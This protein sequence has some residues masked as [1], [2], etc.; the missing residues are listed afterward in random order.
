MKNYC[1]LSSSRARRIALAALVAVS[2]SAFGAPLLGQIANNTPYGNQVGGI[3]INAEGVLQNAS[4][5]GQGK[6]SAVL[7]KA[8]QKVPAEMGEAVPLRKVSLRGLEMAIQE[9]N[10]AGKALPD[11]VRF[12]GGLQSIRYV[13]VYPEQRDI[14]LVGPGEGWKVDGRGN[15]IG[16]TTGRP[17]MMLEDLLV[18]L[19]TARQAAQGGIT[20]SIDP[21][22]EGLRQLKS[23]VATLHTIGDPATTS[24]NIGQTLGR[25]QITFHGVPT[26]S[27]FAR[28]L[29]GADYRMKRLA[30]NF[31]SSPVRGLPSFLTMMK[32]GPKGMNSMLPRWWL[33]PKYDSLL[34]DADGLAWELSGG[35][36]KCMTEEDFF[37]ETSGVRE[38]TFKANPVAQKWADNMTDHYDQLAV[39][40]PIFGDL[41]NCMELAIV[42]A[43]IVKADLPGKAGNSLPV[44]MDSTAAPVAEYPVPK[45][46]DSQVSVLKK[47]H[48]WLISA[49]GGVTIQSWM[50]ADKARQSD[51]PAAIRAKT[52][53]AAG[54]WCW[55]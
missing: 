25:Q 50:I 15:V 14:L 10:K 38:H 29:V 7:A 9:S 35:S 26:S 22:S 5:D 46:V 11:E 6:L 43:L 1:S 3:S 2:V 37:N 39:A 41:R 32:A 53:P 48:N 4:L 17:V 51:A 30:M 33:E 24:A 8:L 19:R 34:H 21:T 45:Q 44:L 36:V 42:G 31:E 52:A 23:Y 16:V 49:S 47:G 13:L 18:A 54:K 12:L 55:N 27:H 40:E 20:C 28:V